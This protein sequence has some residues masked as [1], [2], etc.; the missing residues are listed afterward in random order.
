MFRAG[1]FTPQQKLLFHAEKVGKWVRGENVYPILVEFDLSNACNHRCNFCNSAETNKGE[2]LDKNVACRIVDELSRLGIK[3]IN[4]TGGGEPLLNPAFGDIARFT[5]L[6]RVEQGLYT[7]GSLLTPDLIRVILSTHHWVKVSL[8]AG[9]KET[10][11]KIKSADYFDIVIANIKQM[12]R[13]REDEMN[14][15]DIGID[16]V[17]TPDNYKE[18]PLF[19]NIVKEIGVDYGGF[20]PATEK[21][22]M[23]SEW[24]KNEVLPLLDEAF[25]DNGKLVM[26]TYKVNDIVDNNLDQPYDTCFGHQFCPCIGAGGEVWICNQLRGHQ[27]YSL[28]NIYANSFREIWNGIKRKKVVS[29]LKVSECPKLCKN[30]EIN[31]ILALVKKPTRNLHHNFL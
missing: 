27:K 10:Y 19:S 18:I 13:I 30:N 20:R 29:A 26:N 1:Q 12:V 21:A 24:Y 23:A 14:C 3:A 6:R 28:G 8:D 15:C 11:K 22:L 9:T 31:K 25:K 4:W 7:N 17:I 5:T 2:I 16:F